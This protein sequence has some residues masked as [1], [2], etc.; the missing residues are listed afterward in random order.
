[1]PLSLSVLA[2]LR[3]AW[4]A[5]HWQLLNAASID[6]AIARE[7][8]TIGRCTCRRFETCL[9][10]CF[11]SAIR[12]GIGKCRT[13]ILLPRA[14]P[15]LGFGLAYPVEVEG[16]AGEPASSTSIATELQA[17]LVCQQTG[18]PLRE[19]RNRFGG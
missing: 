2:G 13:L 7:S 5:S 12:D 17:H 18:R 8:R 16:L 11:T 4:V 1:M 6:P 19:S 15:E 10:C 9:L 14:D 3:P